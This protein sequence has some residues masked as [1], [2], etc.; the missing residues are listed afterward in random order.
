M[1]MLTKWAHPKSNPKEGELFAAWAF[2]CENTPETS[3]NE[4]ELTKI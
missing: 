1:Q 3:W 4:E 2:P